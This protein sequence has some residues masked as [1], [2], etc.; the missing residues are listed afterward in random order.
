MLDHVAEIATYQITARDNRTV[1]QCYRLTEPSGHEIA[2]YVTHK[3][4]KVRVVVDNQEWR[5]I[6]NA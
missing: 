6:P 2:I 1:Y 3:R 5:P 4:G